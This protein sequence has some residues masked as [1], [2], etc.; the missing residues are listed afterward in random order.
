MPMAVADLEAELQL[1]FPDSEITIEDLAGDWRRLDERIEGLSS[2]IETIARQDAGCT[3][4][5]GV[6]DALSRE[7]ADW[8]DSQPARVVRISGEAGVTGDAGTG[9]AAGVTGAAGTSGAAG[10]TGSAGTT[11]SAGASG[12]AQTCRQCVLDHCAAAAAACGRNPTCTACGQGTEA[13]PICRENPEYVAACACA[14][15][16]PDCHDACVAY[17]P[18]TDD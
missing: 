15:A 2:E 5:I 10:A 14:V 13:G 11:G 6:D 12:V 18:E 4:V 17:C 1:A 9:G 7:M 16:T 8:L 3:A